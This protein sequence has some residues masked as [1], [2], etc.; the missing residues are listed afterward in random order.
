M[1]G[2][3]AHG[4]RID[5]AA[6]HYPTAP[7]PWLDLS[8]GINPRAWR[9]AAATDAALDVDMTRLPSPTAIAAL[10]AA[11]AAMFGTS[12][13]RVV[14]LPG[15]EIGLRSLRH[16]GLPLPARFVVP[17]YGTHADAFP[18]ATPIAREATGEIRSGT[19]LLANPNNPDGRRDR[20][21]DLLEIARQGAWLVV[22][23]A[24]AD[25]I[26][27]T[28][29]VPLLEP[30]DRAVV[31]RSF[32][33][34]FGLP[35]IRL[36]F[37]IAPPDQVASMRERLGSWP[38][39]AHAVAYGIAA[40][41]DT[42]WIDASRRDLPLRAARLDDVLRRY[43]TVHGDCP[44]FRVIASDDAPALFE[45]LAHAGIL[46]RPF[47]YAPRWLRVGL[48]GDDAAFERLERALTNG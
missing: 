37:M 31:F 46:T 19:L 45:R 42:D 43:G 6:S 2:L 27:E 25:A 29:V 21:R 20:P 35:G 11:A 38:V 4:G 24:F 28:S 5:L 39:S 3:R 40:Y 32:G 48:P 1:T 26:S 8:T 18:G 33:K 15:S 7:R 13:D 22:D 44:L 41:R 17:C 14:A 16:L 9:A 47:D 10:E 12:A 36:G 34:F 30:D 23:E